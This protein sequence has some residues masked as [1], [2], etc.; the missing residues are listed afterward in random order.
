MV[1]VKNNKVICELSDSDHSSHP[2]DLQERPGFTYTGTEVR[3]SSSVSNNSS[4]L[5]EAFNKIL[6]WQQSL[7]F[8]KRATPIHERKAKGER[9]CC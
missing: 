1:P 7:S 9:F 6:D 4:S 8:S 2:E 3:D 5:N